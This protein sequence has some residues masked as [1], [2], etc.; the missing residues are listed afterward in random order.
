MK[1]LI[2]VDIQNDYFEGGTMVLDG[3]L[4]ASEKAKQIIDKFRND[5]LPVIHIQH[6][7]LSPD[8]TFFLPYTKGA[9]FHPNV[10]PEGGEI[11]IT[12]YYPNSFLK[13]DLQKYL[14]KLEVK[15]LVICGMMTHMCID[16]TTRAAKDLGYECTLIGDACATREL[17]I[18]GIKVVSQEVHAAF[19]SALDYYYANVTTANDYLTA[20]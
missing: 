8:A 11:V 9:E 18:S 10:K 19:L 3:A 1:A 6:I 2:V 5:R 15:E 14:Q 20:N 12:K 13:T 16:A 4:E 7:A 17:E